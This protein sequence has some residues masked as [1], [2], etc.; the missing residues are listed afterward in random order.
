[1]AYAGVSRVLKCGGCA[2]ASALRN[3]PGWAPTAR[4]APLSILSH[5]R[6]GLLR[7]V[8]QAARQGRVEEDLQLKEGDQDALVA[9]N[10]AGG[11]ESA[12]VEAEREGPTAMPLP[13][14]EVVV[15]LAE[16][17]QVREEVLKAVAQ[18]KEFRAYED[19]ADVLSTAIRV[20][21]AD[22]KT[23]M[24][25]ARR[26]QMQAHARQAVQETMKL[27]AEDAA[28]AAVDAMSEEQREKLKALFTRVEAA[29]IAADERKAAQ[30]T[31]GDSTEAA[32]GK[33]Q[34][35]L[36]RLGGPLETP[37]TAEEVAGA[38]KFLTDVITGR[39]RLDVDDEDEVPPAA[40]AAAKQGSND[41][42]LQEG[43][44]KE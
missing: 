13:L 42:E 17:R 36:D 33:R 10:D 44:A 41:E 34:T 18:T 9:R 25:A 22:S 1:M 12:V 31:E 5:L 3:G 7:R 6:E 2:A 15:D 24:T 20:G 19:E 29:K 21:Y 43:K 23:P 40:S 32:P 11:Q 14:E 35:I 26:A 4:A 38:V 27:H 30:L 8:D 39:R 28:D 37:P 16:G